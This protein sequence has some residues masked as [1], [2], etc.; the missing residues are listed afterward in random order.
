MVTG[1]QQGFRKLARLGIDIAGAL[2]GYF[3][4]KILRIDSGLADISISLHDLGASFVGS[5]VF[6]G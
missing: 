3:L 4:F 6:S 2:I 1:K 5:L